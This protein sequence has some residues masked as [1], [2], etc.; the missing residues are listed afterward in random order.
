MR[1]TDMMVA[2][3]KPSATSPTPS[4]STLHQKFYL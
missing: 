1:Y 4:T 2:A 3:T